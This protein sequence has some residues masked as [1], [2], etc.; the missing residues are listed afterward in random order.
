MVVPLF[1]GI[2]SLLCATIPIYGAQQVRYDHEPT[3][4]DKLLVLTGYIE[5]YRIT[6]QPMERLIYNVE[7]LLKRVPVATLSDKPVVYVHP[8][9]Q[10][11]NSRLCVT[12]E[13]GLIPISSHEKLDVLIKLFLKYDAHIDTIGYWHPNT[14]KVGDSTTPLR[15]AI[16]H[17]AKPAAIACL[18]QCKA[19]PKK[20]LHCFTPLMKVASDYSTVTI[21]EGEH[22]FAHPQ[23]A[24]LNFKKIVILL[25]QAGA[26]INQQ[27]TFGWTAFMCLNSNSR[28]LMPFMLNANANPWIASYD[29]E[30]ISQRYDTVHRPRYTPFDNNPKCLANVSGADALENA[31]RSEQPGVQKAL[32]AYNE[33]LQIYKNS[34][35]QKITEALHE[36]H[37]IKD[38]AAIVADYAV[39][40]MPTRIPELE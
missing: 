6:S 13:K 28:K 21:Y 19:D 8:L 14:K 35:A 11:F 2:F 15:C 26:D 7:L 36:I 20:E 3:D 23:Q 38:L 1:L 16:G 5:N 39:V 37:F 32:K 27:N 4:Q 25:L 30:T 40:S 17:M 12:T 33:R 10:I 9:I 24:T 34:Y 22:S 29:E 31:L 18:L